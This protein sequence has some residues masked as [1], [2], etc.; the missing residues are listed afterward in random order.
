M[1]PKWKVHGG[2]DPVHM[3]EACVGSPSVPTGIVQGRALLPVPTVSFL[4]I[5]ITFGI[6]CCIK[7]GC[8]ALNAEQ[9]GALALCGPPQ[10]LHL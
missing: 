9:Y 10:F 2:Q 4:E 7:A 3:G 6:L 8:S 5:G 1:S